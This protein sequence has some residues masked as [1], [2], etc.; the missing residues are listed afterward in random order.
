M[1]TS[2]FKIL[3]IVKDKHRCFTKF[4]REPGECLHFK[5]VPNFKV[6]KKNGCQ[7]ETNFLVVDSFLI[8]RW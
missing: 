5:E 2:Y 7:L 6:K 8:A 1:A 3:M 4:D